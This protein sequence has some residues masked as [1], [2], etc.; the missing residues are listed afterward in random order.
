MINWKKF[1]R[2]GRGL[3]E[4]TAPRHLTGLSL[5]IVEVSVQIRTTNFGIKVKC[6]CLSFLAVTPCSLAEPY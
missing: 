1:E 5:R 4:D 3:F 6:N 2:N